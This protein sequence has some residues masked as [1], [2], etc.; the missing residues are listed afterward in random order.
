MDALQYF[1]GIVRS[2]GYWGVL[3]GTFFEG[4]TTLI[5][6]GLCAKLGLLK[7]W[8]VILAALAGSL[9]GDQTCFWVGHLKGR[10]IL[11][12]HPKWGEHVHKVHNRIGRYRTLI[13]VGF[14]FVYGMRMMTP[15]VIGLDREIRATKF[16][17]LNG[18]GAALWSV[19]IA[20]GGYFFG[21]ALR[22]FVDNVKHYQ[23]RIMVVGC[24]IGVAL[25]AVYR[26]RANRPL[27]RNIQ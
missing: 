12:K 1:E 4:E 20:G 2:Y 18:I 9:L 6:G 7:L 24:I 16:L 10:Q 19:S 22:G 26:L 3:L 5:I 14:R 21:F 27:G 15:F 11:A 8:G 25:W 17:V 23:M 13:M